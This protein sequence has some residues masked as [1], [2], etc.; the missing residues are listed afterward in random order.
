MTKRRVGQK[1]YLPIVI[2]IKND[3]SI[4]NLW[5]LPLNGGEAKQIT[6]FDSNQIFTFAISTDGRLAL[7]RGNEK[8]DV[9]LISSS[10]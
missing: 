3:S 9:V 6:N 8:S 2:C 10:E 4:S 7:S 1:K 5:L